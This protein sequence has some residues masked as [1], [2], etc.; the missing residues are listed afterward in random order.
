[1]LPRAAVRLFGQNVSVRSSSGCLHR[2]D[3]RVESAAR[4]LEIAGACG[5]GN[6]LPG[7]HL[8]DLQRAMDW[9]TRGSGLEMQA[10]LAKG[11]TL[12][13]AGSLE[14]GRTNSEASFILV[15]VNIHAGDCVRTGDESE[16]CMEI[17]V[18]PCIQTLVGVAH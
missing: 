9:E 7:R 10:L 16:R 18:L 2:Y 5:I 17:I 14:T 3:A 4:L 11:H 1:M 13:K 15:H 6:S 8:F 12:A